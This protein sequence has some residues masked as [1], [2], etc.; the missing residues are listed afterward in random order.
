MPIVFA[1][2][3]DRCGWF[4]VALYTGQCYSPEIVC[5]SYP[6]SSIY[7][8]EDKQSTNLGAFINRV[9]KGLKYRSP[10]SVLWNYH[11]YE[12]QL[13]FPFIGGFLKRVSSEIRPK[14][15]RI[16]RPKGLKHA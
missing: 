7:G 9:L 15:V 11:S 3:V 10:I 2:D 12:E 6:I 1:R 13:S 8:I 4:L 14:E 5:S 16:N